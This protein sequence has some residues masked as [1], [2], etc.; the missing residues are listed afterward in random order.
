MTK[1]LRDFIQ[2]VAPA[3]NRRLNLTG[4]L[5]LSLKEEKIILERHWQCIDGKVEPY[6][7]KIELLQILPR[8]SDRAFAGF[9]E[10]LTTHGNQEAAS[11]LQTGLF[12]YIV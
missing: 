9:L 8:R 5:L 10:A 4:E 6:R 3:V 1:V 11:I 12:D 7:R 2:S